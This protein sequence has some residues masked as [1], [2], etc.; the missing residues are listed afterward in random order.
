VRGWRPTPLR[1]LDEIDRSVVIAVVAVRM[2][3]APPH[4]VVNVVAMWHGLMTA[5]RPMQM[6][7]AVAGVGRIV[8]PLPMGVVYGQGVLVIVGGTP[9]RVRMVKVSV[10]QVVHMAL[11]TNGLMP[12]AGAMLMI[13]VWMSLACVAHEVGSCCDTR[14]TRM[15]DESGIGG[16]PYWWIQGEGS[17][18]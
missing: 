10:V 16:G 14:R 18:C 9:D 4:D 7:L 6:T 17:D 5:A 13:M 15:I 1:G 8:T 3:Q 12:T 11:M 2:M